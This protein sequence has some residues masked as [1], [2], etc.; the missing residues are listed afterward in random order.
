MNKIY[1]FLIFSLL[2]IGCKER[3]ES[4]VVS[5]TTGYLVVEGVVNSGQGGTVLTLSRTTKLDT[6]DIEY[7]RG[8]QVKVEGEDKTTYTLLESQA[9]RYT[10]Q[11]LNLNT[12]KKYRLN[13]KTSNGKVY[14]SDFVV[15]KNNPPIDSITWKRGDGGVQLSINTHD[16]LN[17]TRYYQWE[18]V[19]TWEFQ[20]EFQTFIKYDVKI[21]VNGVKTYSAVYRDTNNAQFF[22]STQYYC[23]QTFNSA[24]ILL[25]T[26]AKLNEDIVY[27]PLTLIPKA[28]IKL[29]LQYSINVK[30]Y[31]LTKDGYDFLD[32]VRKNTEQTGSIFD[33][34][35]SGVYGNIHNASDA[36]EQIGRAHV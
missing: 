20:S 16:P 24:K 27:L 6:R 7:E 9:G 4:P 14:L 3:Y 25:G 30:Q 19:E 22:D 32:I 13:I 11:N 10:A 26:T 8:A 35:P 23:W 34:Q 29:K 12:A 5:P 15:V 17:N 28:S 33:P 18:Y 2:I 21:S 1:V 31:S 36:T